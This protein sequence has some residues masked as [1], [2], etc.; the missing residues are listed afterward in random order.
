M[1]GFV[2][3]GS[4]P[5]C[6]NAVV[7]M[8]GLGIGGTQLCGVCAGAKAACGPKTPEAGDC[9]CGIPHGEEGWIERNSCSSCG[10]RVRDP[11]ERFF[12][13]QALFALDRWMPGAE[14]RKRFMC[15][16]CF[17]KST[18]KAYGSVRQPDRGAPA[19]I[20]LAAIAGG[21]FGRLL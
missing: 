6:G 21:A 11:E 15:R 17:C 9:G 12:P 8:P 18:G 20:V 19:G 14:T 4:C 1:N 3:F 16:E 5:N 10:A 13:P 2:G 7:G